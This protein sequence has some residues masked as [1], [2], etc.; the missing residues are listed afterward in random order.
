MTVVRCSKM[1]KAGLPESVVIACVERSSGSRTEIEPLDRDAALMVR[2][3][4]VAFS[5]VTALPRPRSRSSEAA[6][7]AGCTS[8][9]HPG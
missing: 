6:V 8:A 3:A 5:T 1:V 7:A 4:P 9:S 2:A